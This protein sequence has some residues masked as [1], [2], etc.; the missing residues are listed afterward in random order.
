ML[1]R[2]FDSRWWHQNHIIITAMTTTSKIAHMPGAGGNFMVRVL[3]QG[4]HSE[5]IPEA[6][7]PEQLHGRRPTEH[8]WVAME[9]PWT[10]SPHYEHHHTDPHPWLRITVT[11]R[12]EWDWATANALWKNSEPETATDPYY[13]GSSPLL[14]AEHR[15][16]LAS[17]WHWRTL[18]PELERLQRHPTNTHQQILHQQW[19]LTWCPHTDHARYRALCDRLFRD[20][21]PA[22]IR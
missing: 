2:R 9:R 4:H 1:S 7:Y 16:A 11:T 3:E 12:Q 10:L 14:P 6:Q 17:L 21:R 13:Q 5:L 22:H 19:R 20:C 18:A 15:I 8:D